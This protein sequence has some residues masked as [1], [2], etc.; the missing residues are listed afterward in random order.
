MNEGSNLFL[1]EVK[2]SFKPKNTYIFNLI[3]KFKRKSKNQGGPWPLLVYT[4][5]RP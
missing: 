1:V 3:K 2:P 5:V 4:W